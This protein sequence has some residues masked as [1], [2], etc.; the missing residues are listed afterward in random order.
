MAKADS[1]KI[2]S[3]RQLILFYPQNSTFKKSF[4][5][6][7]LNLLTCADSS[8]DT[9]KSEEEN[10]YKSCDTY[11]VSLVT[12]HM[13]CVMCHVSCVT[14]QFFLDK[15]MKL[16]GEGSVINGAYPL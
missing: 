3:L 14:N 1:V 8:T 12:C 2:W 11:H 10:L 15:V 5:R 7:T 13:S 4:I 16:V 6:E 9:K